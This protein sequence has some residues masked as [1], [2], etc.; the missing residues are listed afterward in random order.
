MVCASSLLSGIVIVAPK[1][2]GS[3][4]AERLCDP[5]FEFDAEVLTGLTS[6]S[7]SDRWLRWF[8]LQTLTRIS[9]QWRKAK[10][11]RCLAFGFH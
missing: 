3:S 2:C 5:R 9:S 4:G 11:W 7:K 10:G 6:T 8:R 1:P